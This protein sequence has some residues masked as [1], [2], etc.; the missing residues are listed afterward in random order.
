MLLAIWLLASFSTYS[1][2]FLTVMMKVLQKLSSSRTSFMP[3]FVA[4]LIWQLQ[5]MRSS[6]P[7]ARRHCPHTTPWQWWIPTLVLLRFLMLSFR[8]GSRCLQ[9]HRVETTEAWGSLCLGSLA[10]VRCSQGP[11]LDPVMVLCLWVDLPVEELLC[12]IPLNGH[13]LGFDPQ[14]Q[15]II[16]TT[17][18]VIINSTTRK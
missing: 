4:F 5:E 17:I 6:H 9:N 18:Y 1:D 2:F 15:T 16:R 10:L 7:S 13:T 8:V 14:T 12:S 11:H 3:M